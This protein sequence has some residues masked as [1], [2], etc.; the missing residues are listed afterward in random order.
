MQSF[1]PPDGLGLVHVRVRDRL[2]PPQV[3]LQSD[4]VAQL[5]YP[6]SVARLEKLSFFS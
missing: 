5:L 1:P 3:T 4:H 6:P 2:P